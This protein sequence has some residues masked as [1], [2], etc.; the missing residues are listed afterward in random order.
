MRLLTASALARA[1]QCQGSAILDAIDEAG[2][3]AAT[4][5][6]VDRY[7]ETAK[8]KSRDVALREA[9]AELRPC[10][11]ALTIDRIPDG[12]EYQVAF[13]INAITGEVKRISSRLKGYPSDLAGTW[14]FGT[15]DII[16]VRDGRVLVWDLKWGTST[17]GRDPATD[18]QLGL[19]AVCAARIAGVDEAEVGFLRAGWDGVLRPDTATLDAMALDAMEVRIA[20]IWTMVREAGPHPRLR[21][22]EWCGYCPAR[23][24][25]P[26]MVQPV[27]LALRGEIEA[28]AGDSLPSPDAVREKIASLALVDKGR[29]YERLDAAVDYLGMVKGIL[30]DDARTAPIPLSDG[31]E[32]REVMWGARKISPAG[33]EREAT[34]EAELR[35]AGEVKTVKVPQVRPMAA[36][37]K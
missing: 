11:D 21:V 5:S 33:K 16:G 22:G 17:I 2:E 31:K 8:T 35:A 30:R 10:L 9:P 12:A 18:L 15:A 29:L 25:C 14:I 19:Y 6:A 1:E 27:A 24:S 36:R 20:M 37:R 34:L 3:Y 26:A 23:R 32:L 28:L 7:V 13:A 4:G